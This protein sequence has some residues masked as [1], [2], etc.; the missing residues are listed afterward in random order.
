MNEL[1]LSKLEVSKLE[2]GSITN[3]VNLSSGHKKTVVLS[4]GGTKVLTVSDSGA[5]CVLTRQ[6]LLTLHYLSQS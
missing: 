6:P 5:T 3:P 1:I 2:V 4:G